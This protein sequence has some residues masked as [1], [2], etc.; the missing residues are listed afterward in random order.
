MD[1]VAG[2]DRQVP[3]RGQLCRHLRLRR[4]THAHGS[5]VPGKDSHT[6]LGFT[7]EEKSAEL[8]KGEGLS[9]SISVTLES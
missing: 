1:R 7:S 9:T 8:Q 3:D 4:G 5:Q 2:H 6:V